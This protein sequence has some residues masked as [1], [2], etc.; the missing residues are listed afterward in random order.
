[1]ENFSKVERDI[2]MQCDGMILSDNNRFKFIYP[3]ATENIDGYINHF[4]LK[5]KSLLTTGSSADQAIN[6]C[7]YGCNDITVVDINPY[8]KFYYYLKRAAIMTL[9]YDEFLEFFRYK[10]FPSTF[11]DNN[12]VFNSESFDKLKD[13]LRLLD[14][15]S[16]LIWDEL[17]QTYPKK[18]IRDR[19]FE[20]D[21][22]NNDEIICSNTYLK[23]EKS[24]LKIRDIIKKLNIKFI[25]GDLSK[26]SGAKTYDNIW[27]S[28]I[29]TYYTID[30][31]K[32][33]FDN[34]KDNL[35][36]N[37]KML[38]C[39]LYKTKRNTKYIDDWGPIYNLDETFKVFK[40]YNLDII[41]FIG[42]TGIKFKDNDIKDAILLYE[43]KVK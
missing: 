23:D 5:N 29:G 7:F 24:Y 34:I 39:Y 41:N 25:I 18:K 27:L 4:N 43:K 6:A 36:N 17:F 3:F 21:E 38:V 12:K 15:E 2:I 30:D 19:L 11:K 40:D 8:T 9:N 35:N 10:N 31:F 20:M 14:Y 42:T 13:T 16:Y 22:G 33:I 28:N 37:G 26:I 1:M 32:I